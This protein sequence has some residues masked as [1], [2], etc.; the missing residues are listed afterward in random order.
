MVVLMLQIAGWAA[1]VGGTLLTGR[2]LRQQRN[3]VTAERTSRVMHGL[4][5]AGLVIP[6]GLGMLYPGLTRYDALLGIPSLPLPPLTVALGAVLLLVGL[7]LMVVSNLALR[8]LG[9]GANAFRLTTRLVVA[10][11]YQRTRNP[12]SLGYYLCCLGLGLL[13]GS[14]AVTVGALVAIIPAHLFFLAYFEELELE[15][16]LGPTYLDYKQRVPFLFPGGQDERS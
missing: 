2:Q 14:T 3:K 13:A 6:G 15:L 5:F 4:F 12:M 8:R 9:H 1:F 16:R 7:Y 10:D 11:I